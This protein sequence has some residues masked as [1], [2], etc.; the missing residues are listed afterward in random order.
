M[1]SCRS[2]RSSRSTMYTSNYELP[3]SID[4]FDFKSYNQKSYTRKIKKDKD[5]RKYFDN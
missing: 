3:H 4:D 5:L 1:K 2:S